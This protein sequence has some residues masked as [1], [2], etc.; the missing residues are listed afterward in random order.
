MALGVG[1]FPYFCK[2]FS[3]DTNILK[4]KI[5][6][7]LFVFSCL[8]V[9][10]LNT[11]VISSAIGISLEKSECLSLQCHKVYSGFEFILPILIIVANH[12]CQR[13]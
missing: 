7:G 12:Y 2:L 9:C 8:L 3:S 4:L 10:V 1:V 5:V 6:D 13:G 11:V